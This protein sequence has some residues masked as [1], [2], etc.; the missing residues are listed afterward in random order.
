LPDVELEPEVVFLVFLPPAKHSFDPPSTNVNQV[1]LIFQNNNR[2]Q[3]Y[4]VFTFLV[5][6]CRPLRQTNTPVQKTC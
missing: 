2:E 6:Y 5:H 1:T 3:D 4:L